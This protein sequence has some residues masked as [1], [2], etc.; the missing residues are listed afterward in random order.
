AALALTSLLF[1]GISP[2]GSAIA[3]IVVAAFALASLVRGSD[4]PLNQRI[5]W[6]APLK[7][8]IQYVFIIAIFSTAA[9]VWW[10]IPLFRNLAFHTNVAAKIVENPYIDDA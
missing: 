5:R 6:R 1:V 3:G 7:R 9:N 10:I 2:P 8:R 4:V